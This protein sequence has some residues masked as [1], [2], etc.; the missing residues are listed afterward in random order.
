MCHHAVHADTAAGPG[1]AA[2]DTL[3]AGAVSPTADG[4][5]DARR[6]SF[7]GNE[8]AAGAAGAPEAQLLRRVAALVDGA[9]FW[10]RI[11]GSKSPMVRQAAYCFTAQLASGWAPF[12]FAQPPAP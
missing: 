5:C 6:G 9:G 7:A 12:P 2:A 10:K 3:A 1:A 8:G 11:Y 4:Q